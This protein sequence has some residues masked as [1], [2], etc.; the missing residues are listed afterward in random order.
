MGCVNPIAMFVRVAFRLHYEPKEPHSAAV[1]LRLV[2][3]CA[4]PSRISAM[5]LSH[6]ANKKHV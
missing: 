6:Y 5:Q 3:C 4:H 1:L 2:G